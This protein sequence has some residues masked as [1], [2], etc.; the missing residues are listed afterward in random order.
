MP[1]KS[2]DEPSDD[3]TVFT[4]KAADSGIDESLQE[5]FISRPQGPSAAGTTQLGAPGEND[6]LAGF[7]SP[8]PSIVPAT[9]IQIGDYQVTKV[10]GKGG[11]GIVYRAR[12]RILKRDVAIK[13]MLAGAH[14]TPE[15]ALR[16]LTEARSV[17][18]LQNPNIVQIFEVGEHEHMPYFALELV[19]GQPLDQQLKNKTLSEHDAATLMHTLCVALQYA[20]DQGI[21]HRDLKPANV[22]M[23]RDGRPKVTDFGLARKVQDDVEESSKT[24]VGTIMGTPSYMSPEQARGDV[25]LLTPATDQYSLGAMLYVM[26]TGRPPFVGARP[27]DTVLQVIHNEP[28]APRQLQP[29]LSVD[30]ET[31]CLKALQKDVAKRYVSCTEMA[32]DLGRF[33]RSEPILARPVGRIE[34]T[35]R[36]CKRNPLIA[37]LSALAVS[38]LVAVAG[39]STW[40]ALQLDLKNTELTQSSEKLQSTNTELIQSGQ[41]LELTNIELTQRTVRLQDFVQAMYNELREFDVAETPRVKPDR[42]RLLNSFNEIMLQVVEELPRE[43][44]AEAIY[45]VV[46]M[47]LA[48]SLIDQQKTDA[49]EKALQE[50]QEVFERRVILK[51]GS[52]ASRNN[53][54]LRL[55]MD[56]ELKRDL[57]RDMQASLKDQ[58]HALKIARDIVDHPKAAA[59]GKGRLSPYLAHWLLADAHHELGVTWFRLG[60]PV[61]ALPHLQIAVQQREQASMEFEEFS[62]QSITDFDQD[63]EIAALPAEDQAAEREF[64]LGDLQAKKSDLISRLKRTQ[65][66]MAS[67]A[68]RNGQTARAEPQLQESFE[69]SHA[70]MDEDPKN[71]KLRHE[72]VGHAEMWAEFLGYT[73]RGPQALVVLEEA[74]KH[75]NDLLADDPYGVAFQ[76]TVTVA[77][78]RLSQWREELQQG[79][80]DE[81]LRQCL[82][83]RRKLAVKEPNNDR[84]QL[85]LMLALS[86]SGQSPEAVA[87][88]EK[89]LGRPNPDTEMLIEIA[90]ALA[91][92][93]LS[94]DAA[95]DL[96]GKALNTL[97]LAVEAG[98]K[99]TVFLQGEPDLKPL[100]DLPEFTALMTRLQE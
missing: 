74:G 95:S 49:A 51:Q 66:A 92:A 18:H 28:I 5:T 89:Y 37:S 24:K 88:A 96:P 84:R 26:L 57:R 11:M 80:F 53:L 25:H 23:T 14:A 64:L 76:R 93:S 54:V 79:D 4:P 10:L 62:R 70:L 56:G 20:H 36:W 85:D 33:L 21:L 99:D 83:I 91:Q 1:N 9:L 45:A 17:A 60:D 77:L 30:L 73:D 52:D 29:K 6:L 63:P 8:D 50:L 69:T 39:I 81:P 2:A 42:D 44:N 19:D 68:F 43:G 41:Q 40:S 61:S 48:E 82:D 75:L 67:A 71:P 32:E 34:R 7:D 46:K 27:V 98:F 78:Y 12:H 90:R 55:L 47:G 97:Q 13:M 59:D 100:R 87:I 94:P 16:F 22:L 58:Q 65:L 86:R 31:I 3:P 38:A 15:D 72:F 35:W